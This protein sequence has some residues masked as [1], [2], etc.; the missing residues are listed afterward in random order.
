[1]LWYADCSST[2]SHGA[3]IGVGV[4]T[5][6]GVGI[7]KG[8]GLGMVMGTATCAKAASDRA[9]RS[10]AIAAAGKSQVNLPR[11]TGQPGEAKDR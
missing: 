4:A 6:A 10:E 9:A 11:L 2:T 5:A 8:V 1:M 3:L 7:G